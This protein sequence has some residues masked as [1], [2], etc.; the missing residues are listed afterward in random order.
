MKK[1]IS[2]I[3]CLVILVLGA[4]SAQAASISADAAVPPPPQFRWSY[5]NTIKT[6]LVISGGQASCTGTV[7][8]YNGITDKVEITLYL[9]RKLASSSVWSSSASDPK[10]TFNSFFGMYTMKK[11]ATSGYEYRVRAVY[12]AYSGSNSETVTGYS[13]T[14][15]Y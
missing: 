8:G 11:A 1:A 14:V 10:Q 2:G 5:I 7:T 4:I 13:N 12:T 15:M 9:E 6:T 3:L